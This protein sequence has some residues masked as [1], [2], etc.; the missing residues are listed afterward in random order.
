MRELGHFH[1]GCEA[2]FDGVVASQGDA[3]YEAAGVFGGVGQH[4]FERRVDAGDRAGDRRSRAR[5]RNGSRVDRPT[6]TR[7]RRRLDELA[8]RAHLL[9]SQDVARNADDRN[10]HVPGKPHRAA[11]V[12]A[13]WAGEHRAALSRP[14][15]P[16]DRRRLCLCRLSVGMRHRL[17]F[18]DA[19]MEAPRPRPSDEDR[20]SH[21]G[22]PGDGP[23]GQHSFDRPHGAGRR[24]RDGKPRRCA[25]GP[26]DRRPARMQGRP[27]ARQPRKGQGKQPHILRQRVFLSVLRM[28]RARRHVCRTALDRHAIAEL[29][30]GRL[31]YA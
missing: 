6:L 1:G 30:E 3:G 26:S 18:G 15:R 23:F 24:R 21:G 20:G 9:P 12:D 7:A 8:D 19:P 17:R 14:V 13:A 4:L 25:S 5:N 11:R 31:A 27:R 29:G 2:G 10:S 28:F 22:R 16:S